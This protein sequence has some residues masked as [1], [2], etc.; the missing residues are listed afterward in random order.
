MHGM[1]DEISKAHNGLGDM[2]VAE[3]REWAHKVAD[4][5]AD[6]LEGLEERRVLP[7][8]QPGDVRGALPAAPPDAAEPMEAIQFGLNWDRAVLYDRI[9][10]RVD[11]MIAAGW[12]EEVQAL[13]DQ[14]YGSQI[15]RLKAL[16]FR[17]I[18]AA[19]GGT[20]GME[21]A[22]EATKM[23]HRRYAKR[24]LTWFRGDER[25]QWLE[26]DDRTTTQQLLDRT[27][28]RLELRKI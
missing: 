10:R 24:Q 4:Q 28:S 12:I 23:H 25:V 3:F 20:K 8:V 22:I 19:L 27:L 14:G 1:K 2:D 21:E 9:N 16:G 17:E 11:G 13:L 5:V 6:Y 26:V 15:Q 18:A 7:E